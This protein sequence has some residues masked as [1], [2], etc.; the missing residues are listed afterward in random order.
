MLLSVSWC[1]LGLFHVVSQIHFLISASSELAQLLQPFF[2]AS[3]LSVCCCGPSVS[4]SLTTA[5]RH[6]LLPLISA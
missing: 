1:E 4:R 3:L 6:E 5:I 2:C